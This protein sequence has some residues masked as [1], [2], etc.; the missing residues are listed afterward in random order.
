MSKM[1]WLLYPDGSE[2]FNLALTDLRYFFYSFKGFLWFGFKITF[3][4]FSTLTMQ[5]EQS[6]NF[7]VSYRKKKPQARKKGTKNKTYN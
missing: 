5:L 3:I 6:L 4:H 7:L 2:A 1:S